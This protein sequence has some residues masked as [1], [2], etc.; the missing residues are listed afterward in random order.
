[1][2]KFHIIQILFA[3]VS[4]FG[5]GFAIYWHK[6]F[7]VS[8][9]ISIALSIAIF[10]MVMSLSSDLLWMTLYGVKANA[11]VVG[12][13]CEQGKKHHITYEFTVNNHTFKDMGADGGGNKTC[14]QIKVGEYGFITYL[15]NMPSIHVWGDAK[16][17]FYDL[18]FGM[19]LMTI[20]VIPCMVH[21]G[22]KRLATEHSIAN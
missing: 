19:L 15:P 8:A 4:I 3:F 2:N 7:R 12:V 13:D 20:I 17:Q 22:F 16:T 14:D 10:T 21:Y 6:F 18:L 5:F 1:M 9:A 11:R